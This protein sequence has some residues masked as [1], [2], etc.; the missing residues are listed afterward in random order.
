M[1]LLGASH[2]CKQATK[3]V[4]KRLNE[5]VAGEK[6]KKGGT[7]WVNGGLKRRGLERIEGKSGM[8]KGD[9]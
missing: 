6:A 2:R 7:G 9:S 1:L 4:E 3:T 8:N 5:G